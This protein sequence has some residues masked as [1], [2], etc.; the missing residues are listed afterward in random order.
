MKAPFRYDSSSIQTCG[1]SRRAIRGTASSTN[2]ART[3]VL[4]IDG[5]VFAR[6]ALLMFEQPAAIETDVRVAPLA[7]DLDRD[8]AAAAFVLEERIDQLQQEVLEPGD[9]LGHL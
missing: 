8:G 3:P 5:I 4:R 7:A 2:S 6:A 1:Y 9:R